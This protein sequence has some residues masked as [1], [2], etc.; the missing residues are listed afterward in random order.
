MSEFQALARKNGRA[1]AAGAQPEAAVKADPVPDGDENPG[2]ARVEPRLVPSLEAMAGKDVGL[3]AEGEK[4][5][6]GTDA[7]E[8]LYMGAASDL[9]RALTEA[10][11]FVTSYKGVLEQGRLDLSACAEVFDIELAAYLLS[12]EE[13]NYTLERI[14]DG[15][16]DEI[17]VHRKITDRQCLP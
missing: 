9:C 5:I 8:L 15:L 6:L 10:H 4:W 2:P 7:E 1:N 13:R 16:G 12:P 17:D 14:R 3:Y 11:V